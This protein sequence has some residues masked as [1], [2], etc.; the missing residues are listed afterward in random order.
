M[1]EDVLRRLQLGPDSN[2]CPR[3]AKNEKP[4][5]QNTCLSTVEENFEEE[6]VQKHSDMQHEGHVTN[7][8]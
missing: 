8:S 6:S 2:N 7:E 3:L 5:K 1:R 4:I